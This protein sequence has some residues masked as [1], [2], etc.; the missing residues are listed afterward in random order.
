[1]NYACRGFHKGLFSFSGFLLFFFFWLFRGGRIYIYIWFNSKLRFFFKHFLTRFFYKRKN[2]INIWFS[3][4]QRL[5][6]YP[7]FSLFFLTRDCIISLNSFSLLVYYFSPSTNFLPILTSFFLSFLKYEG[8]TNFLL[9]HVFNSFQFNTSNF[10]SILTL[11]T[12]MFTK[13]WHILENLG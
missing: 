2:V 8:I 1:M 6:Y 13:T 11:F 9:I 3:S 7:F 10:L 5:F 12:S 4:K